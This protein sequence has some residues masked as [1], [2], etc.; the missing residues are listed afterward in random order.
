MEMYTNAEYADIHFVYGFCDRNYVAAASEYQLRC[1][2]RRHPERRVFESIHRRL[3]ETGSFKPRTDVD[4]GRRNVQNGEAVLDALN[5]DLSSSTRRA[6]SETGLSQNVVWCV[7]R[8][9]K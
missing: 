4:R 5:G 8:E 1:P 9:N 6:V 3:R 2:D 7:F